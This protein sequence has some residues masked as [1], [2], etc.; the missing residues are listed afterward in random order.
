MRIRRAV[1]EDAGLLFEWRNDPVTR[2]NSHHTAPIEWREHERWFTAAMGNPACQLYVAEQDGQPVGT[3]RAERA[4]DGSF[5][6]S[7]TVAP[8]ARGKGVGKEMVALLARQL[9]GV[10]RAEIK[11]GNAASMRIAEAAGLTFDGER[12]GVTYW[13]RKTA[14][15]GAESGKTVAVIQAR[16]GST[17]LPGKVLRPLGGRPMV[18]VVV[19]RVRSATLVDQVVVATST[20]PADDALADLL[21]EQGVATFRGPSEDVLAR[22]HEAVQGLSPAVVVRVTADCPLS[23]PSVIDRVVRERASTGADYASN[24]LKRTYPRGADVE[25]FTY[26]ALDEA[27][28]EARRPEEREH[29][30]P[31]I[32]SQPHRYRLT[33]V[34]A[35]PELHRPEL[36]LTVDTEEDYM[37]VAGIFEELTGSPTLREAIALLDRKPWLTYINRHVEQ[38]RQFLSGDTRR[39]AAGECFEAARLAVRQDLWRPAWWLAKQALVLLAEERQTGALAEPLLPES[40]DQGFKLRVTALLEEVEK[41]LRQ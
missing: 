7:W 17:R 20:D 29:V 12:D 26:Q 37:L 18:L 34:E 24:T 1:P 8:H 16:V 35:E 22:Y 11:A 32:W 2:A 38:K 14:V 30:T 5:V 21:V 19:E 23:E 10:L 9:P 28:R 15:R 3:V 13:S 36:R 6:L 27:A 40:A 33:N 25:V 31:F 4:D 41:R 39:D